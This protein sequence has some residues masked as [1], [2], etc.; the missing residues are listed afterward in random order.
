MDMIDTQK[1]R[2]HAIQKE[3]SV[4]A[5]QIS[6]RRGTVSIHEMVNNAYECLNTGLFIVYKIFWNLIINFVEEII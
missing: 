1:K 6:M 5:V 4:P 3:K 2:S